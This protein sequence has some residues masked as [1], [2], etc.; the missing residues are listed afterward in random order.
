[1][2]PIF[3]HGSEDSL[4]HDIY[5]IF[6]QIPSFKEAKSYC[7]NLK[8]MNPNILVLK[9]GFVF[10][11]FK[12]T[13]DECNNSLFYTYGL[14]K[15]KYNNPIKEILERDLDLKL[16]RT[17][18]GLLSYFSKTDK[19]IEVKKALRSNSWAEK[20]SVLKKLQLSRNINYVKCNHEE[21]FKFF[22]FQIGQ[23]LSLI[24]DGEELF[25]KKSVAKKYPEIE[26]FL[27]RKIDSDESLL[28]SFYINFITLI[29]K[30]ISEIKNER[31]LSNFSGKEFVFKEEPKF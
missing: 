7:Q 19:R 8:E 27:Y 21:L 18:R 31:Y 28:Q 11:S 22:A 4:D 9:D 29:E 14:H 20:Y 26:D 3:T 16:V 1:M 23:T 24:Q 15:Q 25:T 6:D 17:I 12:G 30:E 13:V 10:W 5:V 2:Y